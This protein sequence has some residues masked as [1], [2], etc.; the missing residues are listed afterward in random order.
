MDVR[1]MEYMLMIEQEKS[2]SKAAQKLNISQS[3]LSQSLS[4]LEKSFENPLFV[5]AN[6][7]MVP[8]RMGRI[9]LDGAREMLNVKEE[10]YEAIR[11]LTA[12]GKKLVRIA[13]EPQMLSALEGE[14]PSLMRSRFPGQEFSLLPADSQIAKEYILNHIAD[15][16]FLCSLRCSNSMLSYHHLRDDH[17]ALCVPENLLSAYE[18]MAKGGE[19]RG[20]PFILPRSGLYFRP[21]C[22]NI[23]Q[24]L[25][26]SISRTYEAEDFPTIKR[27]MEQGFGA[28]LLP[29][30]MARE[31]ADCTV[32]HLGE[33]F[34][35]GLYFAV[36]KYHED[37]LEFEYIFKKA[38]EILS[39][40]RDASDGP[41]RP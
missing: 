5:R 34:P 7:Q 11:A 29:G 8:T 18:T 20:I 22:D 35:F 12:E 16:A 37:E 4:R 32:F 17:L 28:A 39:R 21:Y 13:V 3:A 36:P 10:T 14:I 9:Y 27:L 25:S 2:L 19:S 40:H 38:R 1:I 31:A 6:R 30:H 24:K 41:P 23:L 15:A 26:F 33:E